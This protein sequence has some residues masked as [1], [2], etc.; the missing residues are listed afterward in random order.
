MLIRLG[1]VVALV[2]AEGAA[3]HLPHSQRFAP[4]GKCPK[5]AGSPQPPSA[6]LSLEGYRPRLTGGSGP[7]ALSGSHGSCARFYR[8][9]VPLPLGEVG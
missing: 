6:Q 3:S 5:S 2:G 1:V 9:R 7:A 8:R 4:L